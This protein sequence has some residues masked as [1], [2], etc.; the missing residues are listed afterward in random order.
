MGS[1]HAHR[2]LSEVEL[3]L[4]GHAATGPTPGT[5]PSGA[6]DLPGGDVRSRSSFVFAFVAVPFKPTNRASIVPFM[7]QREYVI[8]T[9][10]MT[11]PEPRKGETKSAEL[12]ATATTCE[13]SDGDLDVPRRTTKRRR[14]SREEE[15]DDEANRTFRIEVRRAATSWDTAGRQIWRAAFLLAEYIYTIPHRFAGNT[16]IEL[17]CGIGTT[18]A[19]SNG[20]AA[21]AASRFARLVY[22]TDA[23]VA[24]LE[25]TQRNVDRNCHGNLRLRYFDWASKF[26]S[27]PEGTPS[28]YQWAHGDYEEVSRTDTIIAS[29]VFYD[30]E[31]TEAFLAAL[32][33]LMLQN[34][35]LTAIVTLEKRVVFSA[36]TMSTISLGYDTFQEHLCHHDRT[37]H[38]PVNATTPNRVICQMCAA[39]EAKDQTRG[40]SSSSVSDRRTSSNT[41]FVARPILVTDIP[42]AFQYERISTLMLWEITAT[43]NPA[44]TG[45]QS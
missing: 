2:V 42:H 34:S 18:I 7:Q 31:T 12:T 14:V 17:G 3:E 33:E 21:I 40:G 8:Y 9:L 24:A 37:H 27:A 10:R 20:F 35:R 5:D 19:I 6:V 13:D 15:G 28:I 25:L 23:D 39:S 16:I 4:A 43:V 38:T 30:D 26:M 1:D 36:Y 44:S 11:S 45:N 29:D 41:L 22:A 32:Y